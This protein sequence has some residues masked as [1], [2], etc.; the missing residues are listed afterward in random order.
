MVKDTMKISKRPE[1][2]D[3]LERLIPRPRVADLL[4]VCTRTIKRYESKK[5]LTPHILNCRL[6]AYPENE[7]LRLISNA[8]LT[9]ANASI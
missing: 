2:K 8:R 3:T 7:V 1:K 9:P 5:L 6:T 4:G